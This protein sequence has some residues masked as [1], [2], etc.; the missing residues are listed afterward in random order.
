MIGAGS[1]SGDEV[2]ILEYKDCR[3]TDFGDDR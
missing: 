2:Y 3:L 1:R